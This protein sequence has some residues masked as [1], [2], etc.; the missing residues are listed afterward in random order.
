MNWLATHEYLAAWLALPVA[1]G[2]AL[3]QN[4][5]TRFTQ[6]DWSRTLI[7]FAFLTAL[8]VAF[9]PN[10]ETSAHFA[11]ITLLFTL[12]WPIISDRKPPR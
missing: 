1:I 3:F 2:I 8:A 12:V 7:N 6:F 9:T 5:P 10:V 4:I 11:A